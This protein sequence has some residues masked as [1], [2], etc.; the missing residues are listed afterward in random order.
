MHVSSTVNR[1]PMV[2]LILAVT[3]SPAA[4]QLRVEAQ[5]RSTIPK[6]CESVVPASIEGTVDVAGLVKEAICKGAGDMMAEYTYVVVSLSHEKDKKGQVKKEETTTYEV[7]IPTLREGMRAV[8]VLL[9]T[10]R[11]GVPVPPEELAKERRRAGQRL[12]EAEKKLARQSAPP[13]EPGP[14]GVTGMRPLGM[15]PRMRIQRRVFGFGG[16][17]AALVVQ[18]FL[19]KCELTPMGREQANGRETLVF[20]FAPRPGMQFEKNETYIGLLEGTIWIDAHDRIVTKLVA[21]PSRKPGAEGALRSGEKPPAVLVEMTRLA[22]GVWLPGVIRLNG[23][24]YPRLFEGITSDTTLTYSEYKRF[25]TEI[26]DV[27]MEP[28]AQPR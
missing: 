19:E 20:R 13:A 25:T 11:N 7:H 5:K 16:A 3:V 17:D 4:A 21:W 23:A 12:E 26:T 18:T 2:V 28:P 9:V 24:D 14:V 10:S 8:G 15:Y 6:V 1:T 27:E 22:T